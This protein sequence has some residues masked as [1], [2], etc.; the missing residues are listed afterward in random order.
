ME[1]SLDRLDQ[2]VSMVIRDHG[3]GFD[4]PAALAGSIEKKGLG[5]TGMRERVKLSGGSF[6]KESRVGEGTTIRIS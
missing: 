4:I 1:V 6:S 5:L 2:T 3:I